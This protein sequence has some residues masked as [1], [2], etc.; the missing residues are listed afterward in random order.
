MAVVGAVELTRPCLPV[1]DVSYARESE[2]LEPHDQGT[3]LLETPYVGH[4]RVKH[5]LERV[6]KACTVSWYDR[7]L[8]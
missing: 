4:K 5:N 7:L 3:K 6:V 1:T 8:K 2:I